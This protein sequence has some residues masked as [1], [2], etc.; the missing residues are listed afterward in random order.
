M[1]VL[2][3]LILGCL[4][5][6]FELS[7]RPVSEWH[8]ILAKFSG[9]QGHAMNLIHAIVPVTV[10]L[11]TYTKVHDGSPT[12]GL[13]DATTVT[14]NEIK[15]LAGRHKVAEVL[16]DLINKDGAGSW[17]PN[18][19]HKHSTWPVPLQP[20]KEI[21]LE[22]AELL[23]QEVPSLDDQLNFVRINDFRR[24]F[25]GL[26]V[27]RVDLDAVK[28]VRIHKTPGTLKSQAKATKLFD[29][30][31]AGRWDVFPRDVYNALYC[32]IAS[33]RHAYRWATIPVVQVAQ[34]EKQVE[35]PA[36]LVEPW[37]YMQEYFDCASDSGNNSKTLA[38]SLLL[39]DADSSFK[40]VI[41]C[42]ISTRP[43]PTSIKS[44]Q[45]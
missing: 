14:V 25:R 42:S 27:E 36:E 3:L 11:R 24:R 2:P 4:F 31:N 28:Q 16:H 37:R 34:L 6:L 8:E 39:I 13:N 43:A 44:T 9:L 32:C 41:S 35:L 45:A 38:T 15:A 21:Y 33:C 29:A 5:V 40:Q 12:C 22:L 19:N 26:L 30:A 20:Y 10:K 7:L 17:P 23:P 1:D 18:A